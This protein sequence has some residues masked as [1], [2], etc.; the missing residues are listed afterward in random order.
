VITQNGHARV[1][2][3]DLHSYEQI[4][5]SL[6]MLKI[7]AQGQDDVRAKRIKPLKQ[8]FADIRKKRTSAKSVDK[9][10]KNSPRRHGNTE[11]QRLLEFTPSAKTPRGEFKQ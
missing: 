9:I 7:L 2:I 3:Q 10:G 6:A 1:I 5:D 8:S 11:K 4:Q